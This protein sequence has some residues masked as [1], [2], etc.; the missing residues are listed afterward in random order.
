MINRSDPKISSKMKDEG[1]GAICQDFQFE[2]Y[3]MEKQII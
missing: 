1:K 3:F 2:T